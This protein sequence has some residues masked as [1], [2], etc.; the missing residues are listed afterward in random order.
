[1]VQVVCNYFD[2][3]LT[4]KGVRRYLVVTSILPGYHAEL[5]VVPFVI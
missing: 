1:M 5:T 2:C 3:V 4:N